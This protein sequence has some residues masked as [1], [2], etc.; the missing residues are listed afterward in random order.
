MTQPDSLDPTE[1]TAGRFPPANHGGRPRDLDAVPAFLRSGSAH[2]RTAPARSVVLPR[3]PE[4]GFDPGALPILGIAPRRILLIVG[5]IVLSW[6]AISFGR[7]VADASAASARATELRAATAALTD[8]VAALERELT[9]IQEEHFIA[10]AARA[11]RLGTVR[12]IPFALQGDAPPLAADAPGSAAVRLGADS[13][14]GSPF[15]RWLDVLFGP[16]G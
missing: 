1:A 10:L 3:E 7:Q 4:K 2:H 13:A 16:G 5:M 12:E 14:A 9:V 11:Y 6:L 15:D 8:E